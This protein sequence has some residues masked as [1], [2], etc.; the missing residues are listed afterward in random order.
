MLN[1]C[2]RNVGVKNKE[3]W[4]LTSF[5]FRLV[6]FTKGVSSI[7][8]NI[9]KQNILLKTKQISRPESLFNPALTLSLEEM[10]KEYTM[11]VD[12]ARHKWVHFSYHLHNLLKRLLLRCVFYIIYKKKIIFFF[13][14]LVSLTIKQ[15]PNRQANRQQANFNV[16]VVQKNSIHNIRHSKRVVR[17]GSGNT[18]NHDLICISYCVLSTIYTFFSCTE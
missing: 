3:K 11:V 18:R 8:E 1:N 12:V 5:K 13:F 10:E 6:F 9:P 17:G 4:F 16:D 15:P 7:F 14:I 2:E